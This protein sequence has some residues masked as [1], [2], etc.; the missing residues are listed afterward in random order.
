MPVHI[1][2]DAFPT[3]IALTTPMPGDDALVSVKEYISSE[4]GNDFISHLEGIWSYFGRLLG[5]QR[6]MP[7]QVD[8]FL[9]VIGPNKEATLFCNELRQRGIMR[10]KRAITDGEVVLRDD[11]ATIE[12]LSFQDADGNP[13]EIPPE[14]GV[15]LILSVGWRKCL[16]YDFDVLRPEAPRGANPIQVMLQLT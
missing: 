12:A 3:G 14:Y 10:P 8:H 13:I 9:A 11:I 1:T 4:D 5:H 7:S 2:L 15:V 16:Y 6:I